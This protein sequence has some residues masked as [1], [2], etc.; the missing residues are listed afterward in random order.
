MAATQKMQQSLQDLSLN[1]RHN[2]SAAQASKKT[3]TSAVADSWEDDDDESEDEQPITP[4]AATDM[5]SAPPPTPI[6]P[7]GNYEASAFITPLG[8]A[9]NGRLG[10]ADGRPSMRPEKTDAAARRMIAGALG[11]RAPKKTDEQKEYE[12]VMR[13]K[14]TKR[15]EREKQEAAKA[16]EDAVRARAAV[17]DD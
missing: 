12:R 10:S 16:Q 1:T 2:M 8:F 5:P 3:P 7:P 11:V 14:E 15:R 13:E 4:K 17:W 9:P 6:S